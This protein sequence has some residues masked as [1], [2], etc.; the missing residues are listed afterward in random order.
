MEK[1]SK[2]HNGMDRS[3]KLTKLE[4]NSSDGISIKYPHTIW[5]HGK[6]LLSSVPDHVLN[7][8]ENGGSEKTAF[9]RGKELVFFLL[10]PDFLLFNLFYPFFPFF[11]RITSF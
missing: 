11:R 10:P 5:T 2:Q 3:N 4:Y 8:G 7:S 6:N 9:K 1:N